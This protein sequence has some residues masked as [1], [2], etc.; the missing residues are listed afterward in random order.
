MYNYGMD[1]YPNSKITEKLLNDLLRTF[2]I[3]MKPNLR[4]FLGLIGTYSM[5]AYY[6]ILQF[7]KMSHFCRTCKDSFDK[8][9][10]LLGRGIGAISIV[11]K[12]V[13]VQMFRGRV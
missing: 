11:H 7:V 10:T 5:H 6:N 4:H 9:V 2:W 1:F 13:N 8:H 12:I 3:E